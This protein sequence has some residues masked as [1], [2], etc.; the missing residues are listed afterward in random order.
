MQ[1]GGSVGVFGCQPGGAGFRVV[2]W[3]GLSCW[4]RA[5]PVCVPLAFFDRIV[6]I[7]D[8]LQPGIELYTRQCPVREGSTDIATNRVVKEDRGDTNLAQ[9]FFIFICR[10]CTEIW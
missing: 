9:S 6:G 10:R 2:D 4:I 8:L 3:H 7:K 5:V 1:D